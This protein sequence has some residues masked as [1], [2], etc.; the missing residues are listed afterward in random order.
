MTTRRLNPKGLV[1]LK[2]KITEEERR[3][4]MEYEGRTWSR[5]HHD[6]FITKYLRLLKAKPELVEKMI[7]FGLVDR[8]I[9]GPDQA[10]AELISRIKERRR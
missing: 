7:L 4:V 1:N 6:F 3:L 5:D 9:A 2:F 8:I 10:K